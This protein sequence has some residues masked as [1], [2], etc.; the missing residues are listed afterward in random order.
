MSTYVISE[1]EVLDPGGIETYRTLAA[2]S[3][4][5]MAGAIWSAAASL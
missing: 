2:K 4:R 3:M 1:L 5:N